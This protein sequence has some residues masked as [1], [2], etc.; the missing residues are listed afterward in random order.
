MFILQSIEVYFHY[1]DDEIYPTDEYIGGSYV[2]SNSYMLFEMANNIYDIDGGSEVLTW[3]TLSYERMKHCVPTLTKVGH[4]DTNHYMSEDWHP[5]RK[6]GT[7]ALNASYS[8][9]SVNLDNENTLSCST[10]DTNASYLYA[11]VETGKETT[12]NVDLNVNNTYENYLCIQN[13]GKTDLNVVFSSVKFGDAKS[14]ITKVPYTNGVVTIAAG[15]CVEFSIIGQEGG[16][17]VGSN[18]ALVV[19]KMSDPMSSIT[20]GEI[21]K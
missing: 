17:V 18:N 19:V 13:N 20:L 8:E 14:V 15:R 4:F 1:G 7:R 11:A 3:M 21:E 9:K 2:N 6:S 16:D 12:L 5:S 10:S